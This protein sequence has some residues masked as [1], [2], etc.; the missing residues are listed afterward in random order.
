MLEDS[1][2]IN[3][4]YILRERI[5]EDTFSEWWR[6]SSIFTA[7]DFLLRFLK[8]E[9]DGEDRAQT[10]AAYA[11]DRYGIVAPSILDLVEVD[12][13][14]GRL[15]LASEFAGH[16]SLRIAL[17]SGLRFSV[18]HACR[19]ILEIAEGIDEFHRRGMA[20]GLLAP[21]TVVLRRTGD[22][23]E[24]IKI[25][26][27]GYDMLLPLVPEDRLEDLR[28][29]WGYASPELKRKE[30][31]SAAGDIYSLGVLLF[32]L[33]AGKLPYGSRSGLRGRERSASPSHVAAALARRGM[34]RELAAI[35]VR[36]LRKNPLLRHLDVLDFIAELRTLLESR[37]EERLRT[38]GVDPIADLAMLNL[39]KANAG[40]REIKRSLE[41]VDYFRLLS[42]AAVKD[43]E[44]ELVHLEAPF[45][46]EEAEALRE[47][48]DREAESAEDDDSMSL[49]A[50]LD[51]GYAAGKARVITQ[52]NP[53]KAKPPAPQIAQEAREREE[54]PFAK[55]DWNESRSAGVATSAVPTQNATPDETPQRPMSPVP[56]PPVLQPSASPPHRR[57][58]RSVANTRGATLTALEA[59]SIATIRDTKVE[60]ISEP[61]SV[62]IGGQDVEWNRS[63][64]SPETIAAA[65]TSLFKNA[66]R[67]HGSFRF[68]ENPGSG[69]P[70]ELMANAVDAMRSSAFVVDLGALPRGIELQALLAILRTALALAVLDAGKRRRGILARRLSSADTTGILR[71]APLGFVLEGENAAAPLIQDEDLDENIDAAVRALFSFAGKKRPLIILAHGTEAV[72]PTAHQFFLKLA[73]ASVS[74][75]VCAFMFFFPGEVESW[76][77]LSALKAPRG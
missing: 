48:E 71:A 55:I 63:R 76:H 69:R 19:L 4:C 72:G 42:E 60:S 26:K 74:S 21:E 30:S 46:S 33:L 1:V 35:V 17:D 70:A 40:A 47:L 77:V 75:P 62:P 64:A 41:T 15:F 38:G 39:M 22:F 57:L 37:R 23:I 24:E 54:S 65:L 16:K 49:E 14:E 36:S 44:A 32:R 28:E 51:I 52:Q 67:G 13:Y 53:T 2:V 25:L 27:P 12:R 29:N 56:Q 20:Y 8:T 68:I 5:G 34:P 7:S 59:A 10:F 3:K 18:E 11:R 58:P 50:I 31:P 9:Y 73:K 66:S 43:S 45:D 6:A 61:S